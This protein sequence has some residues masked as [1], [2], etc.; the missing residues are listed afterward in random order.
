M[1]MSTTW[2]FLGLLAGRELA[3]ANNLQIRPFPETVM[4]I[5]VDMGKAT[6]GLGVSIILAFGLPWLARQIG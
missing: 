4:L 5:L 3:I 1:P 6:I 2:V